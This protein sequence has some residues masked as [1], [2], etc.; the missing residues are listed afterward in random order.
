MSSKPKNVDDD[1][2][3]FEWV[4]LAEVSVVLGVPEAACAHVETAIALLQNDH[5][6]RKLQIFI[7]VL[8][9]FDDHF[10]GIVAPLLGFL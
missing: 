4:L 9:Q 8:E 7:D 1:V 2:V 5:V 10:T 3:V 6:G